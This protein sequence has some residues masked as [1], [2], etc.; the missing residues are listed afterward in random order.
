VIHLPRASTV[1]ARK[2]CLFLE[3]SQADFRAFCVAAPEVLEAFRD[4]IEE[5][6]IPLKY[7]IHN[8]VLQDFMMQYM[9]IEKSPENLNFWIAAC[10]QFRMSDNKDPDAIRNE[11]FEILEKYIKEGSENQVNI[12]GN[13]RKDILTAM[14]SQIN[15][16]VFIKAEEEVLALMTRDTWA[17][18]KG[19]KL[20]QTSLTKM[21]SGQNYTAKD[22]Q[23]PEPPKKPLIE[24]N[25]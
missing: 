22:F 17:R 19:K 7:L 13:T 12:L 11:A 5:Y 23:K 6:Q 16:D 20:F 24:A 15:R 1:I 9:H 18:F 10:K 4:K 25:F 3:L 14:K 21:T 8:P 2:K